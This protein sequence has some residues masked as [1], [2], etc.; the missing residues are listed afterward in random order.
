MEKLVLAYHGA[1][2]KVRLSRYVDYATVA[3]Q[4]DE[5]TYSS[6]SYAAG[7]WTPWVA[8]LKPARQKATSVQW[9]I[10]ILRADGELPD[11]G[12]YIEAMEVH[13]A[14]KRGYPQY[15]GKAVR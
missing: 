10:E 14:V 5:F 11:A 9:L 15:G 2:F 12:P 4:V 13:A 8:F 6:A 7:E 3:D 1:V